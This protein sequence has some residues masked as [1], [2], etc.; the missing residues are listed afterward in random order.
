MN[1]VSIIQIAQSPTTGSQGTIL[2]QGNHAI[3]LGANGPGPGFGG[4]DL[5]IADGFR[6][7]GPQQGATLVSGLTKFRNATTVTHSSDL[8]STD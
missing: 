5:T 7:Q 6:G 2:G 8:Y 3:N 4:G 1:Q